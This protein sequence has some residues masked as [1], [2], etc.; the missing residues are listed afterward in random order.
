M[1]RNFLSR[2]DCNAKSKLAEMV[3]HPLNSGISLE[4]AVTLILYL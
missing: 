2:I 3:L 4:A 1:N